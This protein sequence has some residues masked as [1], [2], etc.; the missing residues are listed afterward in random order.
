MSKFFFLF[1]FYSF[2]LFFLGQEGL[3]LP[4]TII[5]WC[6]V[7]ISST[8]QPVVVLYIPLLSSPHFTS[9]RFTSHKARGR[10]RGSVSSHRRVRELIR[11]GEGSSCHPHSLQHPADRLLQSLQTT[12]Q[13]SFPGWGLAGGGVFG[14]LVNANTLREMIC[15]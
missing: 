10:G 14:W 12:V 11:I 8:G 1:F 5:I 15:F 9:I 2:F 13:C 4:V 3:L 6:W 7:T